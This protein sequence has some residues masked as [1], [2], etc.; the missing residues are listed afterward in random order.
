MYPMTVVSGNIRRMRILTDDTKAL[1]CDRC[2]SGEAWKCADCLHL[3]GEMYDHLVSD[4]NVALKWFCDNCDKSVMSQANSPPCSQDDKLDHLLK[5]IEKLMDCYEH[6]EKSLEKKCDA[7]E[8]AELGKRT[9]QLEERFWSLDKELEA[10]FNSVE[11]QLK[12]NPVTAATEKEQAVSD[13]DM[14]KFVVQEEMK[15][16]TEEDQDVES[17]KRNIIIYR[18]PENKIDS[19]SDRKA[20]DLAYVTDLLCSALNYMSRTSRKCIDLA[21]FLRIRHVLYWWHSKAR[22]RKTRLWRIF[23]NSSNLS[24]NLEV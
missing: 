23:G 24:R 20:S 10:K 18:A 21:V 11:N 5:V 7:S 9:R 4:S 6:I 22:N 2:T 12:T 19:V 3:P 8:V 13:E 1:Q 16:I 17:R 15:K 14:I